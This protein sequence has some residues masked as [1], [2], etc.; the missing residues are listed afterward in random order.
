LIDD[1]VPETTRQS[2][3]VNTDRADHHKH[4]A[5]RGELI[6]PGENEFEHLPHMRFSNFLTG[7]SRRLY[8]LVVGGG[9]ERPPRSIDLFPSIVVR[10]VVGRRGT[11]E[12][13]ADSGFEILR[14][15]VDRGYAPVPRALGPGRVRTLRVVRLVAK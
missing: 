7:T 1:P 2:A 11:C 3:Q 5:S 9:P 4:Q 12:K 13:R 14:Y 10:R 6:L 8:R 15:L